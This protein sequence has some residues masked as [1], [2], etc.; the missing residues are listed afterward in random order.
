MDASLPALDPA[1][2]GALRGGLA[3]LFAA[4]ALHKLR[5]PAGF[6]VALAGYA[7]LPPAALGAGAALVVAAETA[8]GLALVAPLVAPL[9]GPRAAPLVA[10]LAGAAGEGWRRAGPLLA[11][12]LLLAYGAAIAASLARGRRDLDCGC[13]GP[14]GRVLPLSGALVARNAALAAGALA[15]AL[16]VAPRAATWLDAASA[17]GAVAMGVLAWI[18]AH[19][20]LANA[21][22]A[23]AR[24]AAR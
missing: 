18:A 23:A 8:A 6:R 17:L 7:V 22:R 20:A 9:A 2:A 12:A 4:A 11:A 10:P 16:P 15:C 24:G 14:A 19:E 3:L 21:W 5:D 13:L 1:V